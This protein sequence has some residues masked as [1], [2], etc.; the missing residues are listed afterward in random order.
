M[1]QPP[2]WTFEEFER[3]SNQAIEN[4]RRLRPE[5][6]LELYLDLFDEYQGVFENLMEMTVDLTALQSNGLQVLTDKK[7]ME[8]FRYLAGPP[9]SNDDLITLA[10]TVSLT[11]KILCVDE[12]LILRVID[13]V[14]INLDRRRFPWV[15]D[16]REPS[17]QER[18][19]AI[20]AS[21]A[22]I[23]TQ[24]IGTWRRHEVKRN[25]EQQIEEALKSVGFHELPRRTVKILR[26]AP[27]LGEF[28]GESKFGFRKAD[29]LVRLWDDRVMAIECK[30]SN[31]SLN[32]LKR[33]NN[34]VAAKAEVWRRDF[35]E[36]QVVPAAAISGVFKL[37]ALEEAQRRGLTIFWAHSINV[38]LEWIEQTRG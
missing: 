20:L 25:Q 16:N 38:M 13:I 17:Q 29:F 23:A 31:S 35:G 7:L 12:S 37:D 1:I 30:V 21:A 24:R 9:I 8:A 10:E 36:T 6:P 19:G 34:D 3:D 28:C 32:S 4:F 11:K 33:L 5:E 22:L 15:A 27:G 2:R 14:L 26:Q 18:E